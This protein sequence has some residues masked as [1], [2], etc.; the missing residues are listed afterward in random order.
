VSGKARR[1]LRQGAHH[2]NAKLSELYGRLNGIKER[3]LHK[4]KTGLSLRG[5]RRGK[6]GFLR[7]RGGAK[8]RAPTAETLYILEKNSAAAKAKA[9]AQPRGYRLK[10]QRERMAKL[11]QEFK[12]LPLHER[13]RY[14]DDSAA[15]QAT[16]VAER[17]QG[18]VPP[19]V[20]APTPRVGPWMMNDQRYALQSFIRSQDGGRLSPTSWKS[21]LVFFDFGEQKFIFPICGGLSVRELLKAEVA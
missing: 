9:Q 17:Q 13:Q 11:A 12:D 7:F 16:L 2:V 1:F 6:R 19:P 10:S 18:L 8:K 5:W 20:P 15:Q 14:I 4:S 3:V 21:G